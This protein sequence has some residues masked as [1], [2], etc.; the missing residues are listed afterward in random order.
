MLLSETTRT[1]YILREP[2][3]SACPTAPSCNCRPAVIDGPACRA[4]GHR[5][6]G[7]D[8]RSEIQAPRRRGRIRVPPVPESSIK[9]NLR[10]TTREGAQP[11]GGSF[12]HSQVVEFA[13]PIDHK[14]TDFDAS[15]ELERG[16]V[17]LRAGY[18]GSWFTNDITSVI[19]DNPLRA[20]DISGTPSAG[21]LSMPVSNTRLGVNGMASVKLP[22]NAVDRV[23][24]GEH[25]QGRQRRDS[26]FNHQHRVDRSLYRL[27]PDRDQRRFQNH[28][29]QSQFRLAPLGE[30]ERQR[31][32]GISTSTTG[33]MSSSPR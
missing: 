26:A 12:G 8:V 22:K 14:L 31:S 19:F 17:L 6:R 9:V 24:R 27:Q 7:S 4:A 13:A 11:F 28:G 1:P 20:T 2:T 23:R 21:R 3:S 5:E 16:R 32:T 33:R 29:A 10:H 15:A 25:A 30:G 18:T